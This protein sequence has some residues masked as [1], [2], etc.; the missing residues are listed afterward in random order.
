MELQNNL[1]LNSWV[2]RTSQISENSISN[3]RSNS[4]C[5]AL[6]REDDKNHN[7]IHRIVCK[8]AGNGGA[9]DKLVNIWFSEINFHLTQK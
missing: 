9:S 6:T 7:C 5:R 2:K 1:N 4:L 3:M 8:I